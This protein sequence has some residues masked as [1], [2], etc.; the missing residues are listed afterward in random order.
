MKA[1]IFERIE[2]CAIRVISTTVS[3]LVLSLFLEYLYF[4]GIIALNSADAPLNNEQ[5]NLLSYLLT[6][7]VPISAL[8]V[9]YDH[10]GG[11]IFNCRSFYDKQIA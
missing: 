4:F 8:Q 7:S 5:A 1:N 10:A 11:P 2:A 6:Y 3:K 9:H